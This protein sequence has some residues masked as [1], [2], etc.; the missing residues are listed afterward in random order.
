MQRPRDTVTVGMPIVRLLSRR[1]IEI[2]LAY[3][4]GYVLL[5]WLSYVHPFGSFG[6]TPWDPQTGLS[7]ALVLLFGAEFMPWLF[8]APVLADGFVRGFA[9]PVGADVAAAVIIGGGYAAATGLLLLPRLRFDPT[10]VSRNSLVLLAATAVGSTAVV[11]TSYVAMLVAFGILPPADFGSA[12]LRFWV[13]DAIGITV[14]TPFLLVLM[15]RRRLLPPSWEAFALLVLVLGALWIVFGFTEALRFQ[16][17]YLFFLPVIWTAV[18][19][20][21]EGVTIGL[22]LTQLGLIMAMHLTGQGAVDVTAY[23]ALMVVLALTGLAV[24][25]LVSEQQRTQQQLRLNQEALSRALRVGTMGEFAAA[26]AH[27]INQP[28]TAISNYARLVKTTADPATA[29]AAS[30]RLIAQVERAA[31]VVRRLRNF[32]RLGR[33]ETAPVTVPRLVHETVAY[34]HA[35]L[36]TQGIELQSRLARDLP[37]VKADA[38]QI[39]QVI[40]N[41][42]R[43]AAEALTDAGRYD[44]KVV[45]EAERDAVGFV[46]IRVRDNGPGFDP[47]LAERAVTPFATTKTDGLG[48]GL[49]LARSIVEAHGGRLSIESSASGAVVSFTLPRSPAKGTAYDHRAH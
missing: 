24:G 7:F 18:R 29:S 8:I 37:A 44:G 21:L 31:E 22:L 38:L 15:T 14:L 6:I 19:F 2:A 30:E 23:Q 26:L 17:F 28:L 3:L 11:A 45:I 32:I 40:V 48:L 16:L 20:G 41:L 27:E 4:V 12:A 34:C 43:N 46:V 49:S 25:V 9:L 42:V 39:E 47:D 13:G 10:L 36:D 33:S 35:E 1:H 5:D